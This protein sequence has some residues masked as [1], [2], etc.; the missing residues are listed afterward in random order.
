MTKS[1]SWWR[2]NEKYIVASLGHVTSSPFGCL[3]LDGG[4]TRVSREAPSDH[5]TRSTTLVPG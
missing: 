3:T 4:S 2:N 5:P 1:A